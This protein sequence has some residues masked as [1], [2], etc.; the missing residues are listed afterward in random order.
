MVTI[1]FPL[2]FYMIYFSQCDGW[3]LGSSFN[4]RAINLASRFTSLKNGF[5]RWKQQRLIRMPSPDEA[6]LAEETDEDTSNSILWG[7][8]PSLNTFQWLRRPIRPRILPSFVAR[9]LKQIVISRS[10][11]VSG[12]RLK[13]NSGSSLDIVMGKI[14]DIEMKFEKICYGSL[15][16]SGGGSL[17]IRELQ[18]RTRRF[19]FGVDQPLR[20][21]YKIYGD[22][23]LTQSDIV[24]SKLFRHG[25]QLLVNTIMEKVSKDIIRSLAF[26]VN[27][28]NLLQ[29]S[30]TRVSIRNRRIHA[31]GEINTVMGNSTVASLPFEVSTSAAVRDNHVIFLRDIAVVL[32]PDNIL[33][34]TNIPI[35][36]TTPIDVDI[37]DDCYIEA[38]VIG[39]RHI[40]LRAEV[41]IYPHVTPFDVAPITKK[42]LYHYDVAT[43]LSKLLTMPGGILI[44]MLENRTGMKKI[45]TN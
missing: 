33:L 29:V 11:F 44:K 4:I 27:N 45:K 20:K 23:Q 40:W 3:I 38:F 15:L 42:A 21:P 7:E 32:N 26:T 31:Y 22:L 24:N 18:L 8:T 37:G 1:L 28:K 34:R 17:Y 25:I 35:F 6:L 13:I 36:S 5:I 2:I 10:E 30:I 41:N 12:L 19:L 43:F 16:I 39:D 14:S 9:L